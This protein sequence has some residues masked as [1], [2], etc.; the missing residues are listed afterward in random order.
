MRKILLILA[1]FFFIELH[2][3][4]TF[5]KGYIITNENQ[6]IECLI[7]NQDWASTPRR[8]EYKLSDS[9]VV[10]AISFDE[11]NLFQI[12]DT[13]H[14][15]K[16]VEVYIDRAPA[17]EINQELETVVLQVLLEGK[18]TLYAENN[19]CFF[20]QQEGGKIKQ[21]VYGKYTDDMKVRE[22][23]SFRSEIFNY[24][25]CA[26][27][28]SEGLK[29]VMYKKKSLLNVFKK[30]NQ[31]AEFDFIDYTQHQTRTIFNVKALAGINLNSSMSP[32]VN[33]IIGNKNN[34]VFNTDSSI[35]PSFALGL[36]LEV[37]LPFNKN[38]WAI[39][40]SP[41][42]LNYKNKSSKVYNNVLGGHYMV[43]IPSVG[44]LA[45][46]YL[47]YDFQLDVDYKYSYIEL[48]IG[49]RRYFNLKRNV[50]LFSDVSYG[51]VFHLSD[52]VENIDFERTVINSS[53]PIK[54]AEI[55]TKT[56]HLVKIGAGYVFN[57]K[58]T[59]ALNYYA[60]KQLSN[61]KGSSFSVIA[62]Y[63]LF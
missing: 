17:K 12:Y 9:D 25:K 58:Y 1:V 42:F 52:P 19:I 8:I 16:K 11:M 48:P 24:L 5:E 3:Q 62:S 35:S 6:R 28:N 50:K 51:V 47:D 55:E 54:L 22:N 33:F 34:E 37:L 45:E 14:Y 31:C 56:S 46:V 4:I 57:D 44:G 20:Y 7:K 59:I 26:E 63:K 38:N 10:K 30:Y 43:D 21:L 2:A 61:T 60:M 39:I 23:N 53:V 32:K 40:I 36:E 27:I 13:P 29:R 15:Y 18:A 41:T 49:L